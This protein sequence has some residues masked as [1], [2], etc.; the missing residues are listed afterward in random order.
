MRYN[1]YQR[2]LG[3]LHQVPTE[4][5]VIAVD[6]GLYVLDDSPRGDSL[7]STEMMVMT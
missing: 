5:H 2:A 1:N 4:V 7:S 3:L 6:L